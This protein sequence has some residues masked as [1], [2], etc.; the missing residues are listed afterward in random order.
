MR[1]VDEKGA[2]KQDAKAEFDQIFADQ[3]AVL[4]SRRRTS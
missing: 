1:T 4:A 3:E 2:E